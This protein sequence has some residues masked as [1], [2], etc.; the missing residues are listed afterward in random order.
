M[1][2]DAY[3]LYVIKSLMSNV[4]KRYLSRLFILISRPHVS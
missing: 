4:G 3:L 2:S 1:Y